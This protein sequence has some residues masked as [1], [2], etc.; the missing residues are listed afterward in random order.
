[1]FVLV[2]AVS[3]AKGKYELRRMNSE[4]RELKESKSAMLIRLRGTTAPQAVDD[5]FSLDT[6]AE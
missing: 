1:M 4:A 3:Y 5:Q 6:S 2:R